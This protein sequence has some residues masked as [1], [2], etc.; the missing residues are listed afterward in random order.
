MTEVQEAMQKI[1]RDIPV[2]G[3]AVAIHLTIRIHQNGAMSV[4]GPIHDPA[5]CKKMLDEAWDS[6]KRNQKTTPALVI[7]ERDL[8][9]RAKESY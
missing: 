3:L 4:E 1:R 6:I 8:D 7:P 9:S 5:F 2:D